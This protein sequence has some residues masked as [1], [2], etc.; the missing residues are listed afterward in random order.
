M[1]EGSVEEAAR[2]I[3]TSR[4]AWALTGAGVSTPSGIPDFRG[5]DGLWRHHDPE[6]VSSLEG[7]RRH[8]EEFYAFW[9]WRFERMKQ[10]RPNPVHEL[11]AE[12]EAR[13]LLRGVITQNIDGLHQAAGSRNV[14]EVHGHART[15]TCLGCGQ[16]YPLAWIADRA[17]EEKVAR[18][19]CGGLVKP[20]VVLFGEDL[21]PD[22]QRAQ[23]E[24]SKCDLLFV[25]GTSLTVWPVAGLVPQ[26]A[27][28]GASIII[29]NRD[30]T[31]FDDRAAVL[32]RG[33]LVEIARSLRAKLE[34]ERA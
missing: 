5:P 25:L 3:R 4:Y 7:F 32:L 13:G 31:P 33:D 12:L 29:A 19:P 30:P 34:V 11:L 14:L 24:V 23:A 9:I 16:K 26:A 20:D 17:R 15:G 2:L 10:A 28:H 18:C 8:P 27:A 22:F 6:R 1:L 21:T